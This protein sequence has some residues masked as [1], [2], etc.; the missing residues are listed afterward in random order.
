VAGTTTKGWQKRSIEEAVSYGVGHRIRIEV[1]ALLNEEA[2]ELP[3]EV[4][5]EY[6]AVIL[7]ALMAEG[8]GGGSGRPRRRRPAMHRLAPGKTDYRRKLFREVGNKPT[9]FNLKPVNTQGPNE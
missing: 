5:Q 3:F 8:A 2:E 1:L 6:A 4:R 7:Q 9:G